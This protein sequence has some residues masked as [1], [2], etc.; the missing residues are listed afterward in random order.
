MPYLNSLDIVLKDAVQINTLEVS[1]KIGRSHRTPLPLGGMGISRFE[2]D[3]RLYSAGLK[4]GVQF[5]FDSVENIEFKDDSFQVTTASGRNFNSTIVIGAYGKRA[6]LDKNLK[7]NF[8]GNKAPWLG[9]KAHY[10]NRNFPENTVAL[11]SFEGGY[12][13]LSRTETGAV[14][15]CYLTSYKSFKPFGNIR[16]FNDEVISKNQYLNDFLSNSEMLFDKPLS[17]AQISFEAKSAVENHMI[18]C[19][20][21]A[22]LIHPLCGNGMAMAIHSAKIAAE[23]VSEY[24]ENPKAVRKELETNYSKSWS[25]TF[26]RRLWWGKKLQSLLLNDKWS[27]TL[28]KSISLSSYLT[29]TLIKKTHGTP[30][31]A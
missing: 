29:N 1:P 24:L 26:G 10:T 6:A 3:N 23:L 9:V 4:K 12:G 22:G 20:D 17:I 13:G 31:K 16:A 27:N 18:M 11:H 7:R 8:I 28:I 5:L 21:A 2:L 19:G 25:D 15:F 14:N 30:I